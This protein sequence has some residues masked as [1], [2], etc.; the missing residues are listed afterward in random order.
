LYL[1]PNLS[2]AQQNLIARD[3]ALKDNLL[4]L[5]V[6]SLFNT[7]GGSLEFFCAFKSNCLFVCLI[8]QYDSKTTISVAEFVPRNGLKS[9]SV[10]NAFA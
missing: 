10:I 3:Y 9:F 8:S 1:S 2:I 4:T 7:S 6:R 5:K